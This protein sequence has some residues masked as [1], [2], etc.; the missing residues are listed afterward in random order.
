MQENKREHETA[1]ATKINLRST[2]A[3]IETW[4]RRMGHLNI[5]DLSA[6]ERTETVQGMKISN[7][8]HKFDCDVCIRGKMARIAFPKE[9]TRHSKLLELIHSDVWTYESRINRKVEV[10]CNLH[11]RLFALVHGQ[12]A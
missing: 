1:A 10:L 9:S 4:H 5:R 7:P 12:D 11:R 6:S 2:E 3:S 8:E